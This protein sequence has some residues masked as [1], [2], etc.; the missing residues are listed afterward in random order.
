MTARTAAGAPIHHTRP[1]ADVLLESVAAVFG[2]S[3]LAVVL[4][5]LGLDGAAGARAVYD[6]GGHVI[7]QNEATSE[8]F[9]MPGAAI[10]TGAVEVALPLDDIAAA[11]VEFA[12]T[13]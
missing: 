8:Y 10:A 3:S 6:A 11:V 4:T 5:G 13:A 7:V 1:S 9:G 2:P 12:G